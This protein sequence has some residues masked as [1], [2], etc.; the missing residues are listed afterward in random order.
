MFTKQRFAQ[1]YWV[2]KSSKRPVRVTFAAVEANVL[3]N[4]IG[5]EM[6]AKLLEQGIVQESTMD[7]ELKVLGKDGKCR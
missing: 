2:N 5:E 6:Y 1:L 7:L 3:I 4:L